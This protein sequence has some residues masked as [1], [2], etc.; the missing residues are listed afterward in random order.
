L[1]AAGARRPKAR[2]CLTPQHSPSS[3]DSGASQRRDSR[4]SAPRAER[5]RCRSVDHRGLGTSSRTYRIQSLPLRRTACFA[6]NAPTGSERAS[7]D[8][9]RTRTTLADRTI[10]FE[11]T[12]FAASTMA[13]KQTTWA[14]TVSTGNALA[15]FGTR[16]RLRST[17]L[18]L[19]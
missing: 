18:D 8:A 14:I 5:R 15:R 3:S 9:L 2:L 4:G 1:P 10:S 7:G 13:S 6:N 16:L 17:S 19:G 12:P 11:C